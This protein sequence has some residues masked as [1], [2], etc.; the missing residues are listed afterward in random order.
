M[1][2]FSANIASIEKISSALNQLFDK[3]KAGAD[4]LLRTSSKNAVIYLADSAQRQVAD[5]ILGTLTEVSPARI[6]IV[7]EENTADEPTATV[8]AL[9]H[10]LSKKEHI[11]SEV[12]NL[13][14][15]KSNAHK[16]PFIIRAHSLSGVPTE[17]YVVGAISGRENQVRSLIH[18]ADSIYFDSQIY[19]DQFAFMLHEVGNDKR[20]VDLAW[21]RL[22]MWRDE[23]KNLF[24]T[25]QVDSL[26][27]AL[28]A[29]H[30]SAVAQKG[31]NSSSA[32]Y[33]LAGWILSKLGFEVSALSSHSFECQ[34]KGGKVLDLSVLLDGAGQEGSLSEVVFRFEPVANRIPIELKITRAAELVTRATGEPAPRSVRAL[35]EESLHQT[36]SRFFL[37]GDPIRSYSRAAAIALELQ[38][39]K[40]GYAIGG[41]S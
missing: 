37:V 1:S 19:F 15:G 16:I 41:M 39:L 8:S 20:L 32:A 40:R 5:D 6:F 34:R 7:S 31:S 27:E 30:I 17:L 22:S 18:I 25:T 28:T 4:E 13:K 23:V 24:E 21:L 2:E 9:C 26:L 38:E 14:V 35:E 11:C 33:I 36:L 12:V 3:M 29:V 10:G